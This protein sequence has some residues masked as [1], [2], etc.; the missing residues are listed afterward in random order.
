MPGTTTMHSA[1]SL[2]AQSNTAVVN[3]WIISETRHAA[4]FRTQKHAH[5]RPSLNVVLSGLYSETVAGST[6]D[7]AH[8]AII[9]KPAGEP[10]A[11]DFAKHGSRCLLIEDDM[12]RR[13]PRDTQAVLHSYWW[14]STSRVAPHTARIIRELRMRDS[15]ASASLEGV[16]REL[17]DQLGRRSSDA[18]ASRVPAWV[19]RADAYL[20]DN[21]EPL[22]LRGVADEVGRDAS[23]VGRV[24]RRVFGESVGEYARRIRLE[25]SAVALATTRRIISVVA[26]DAGF[27]DHSHFVR[28]FRR[29]FDMTPSVYRAMFADS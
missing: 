11:N 14:S 7:F 29:R 3:G 12:V 17:F 6:N 27:F 28:E 22:T 8:G 15:C 2:G 5:E 18:E 4:G 10:H 19:R 13:D 16:V 20:R 21:H 23:H 26:Q 1:G 24:F 9:A 25:R